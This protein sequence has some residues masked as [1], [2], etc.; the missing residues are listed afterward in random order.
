L[1]PS[2]LAPALKR[3]IESGLP[4]VIDVPIHADFHAAVV[5]K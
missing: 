2:G 4:A 5:S 3:A 1:D